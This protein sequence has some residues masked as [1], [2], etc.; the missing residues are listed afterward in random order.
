MSKFTQRS[1]ARYDASA[2]TWHYDVVALSVP[3]IFNRHRDHDPNGMLYALATHRPALQQL[4]SKWHALAQGPRT[5]AE[6]EEFTAH[7][8]VRPLVLRARV[9]DVM[10]VRF[11]NHL[12]QRHV[13]MHLV[14]PG[15]DVSSDGSAVGN[16]ASSLAAPGETV[17]YTWRC[18]HEGSF[19]F[20]DIGDPDGDETGTNAHGLFGALIVEPRH[21]W[22]TDPTQDGLVPVADGLYVDVHQRSESAL[23]DPSLRRAPF[24][25]ENT[26]RPPRHPHPR[27]SFREYVL[28][29]HDEP[30]WR[31]RLGSDELIAK[32]PCPLRH[33][34]DPVEC[35]KAAP[36]EAF[37]IATEEELGHHL[38]SLMLFNYRSEPMK[39]R[40]RLIWRWLYEKRLKETVINEEQHHSSWMFGDP[41]TPVLKSY[42]GDPARIRLLHAAV[43][44]TH[45]FHLHMYEWYRDPQNLRSP[46]IDAISI[47]PQ[48]GHTIVPL[49]GT[50]NTQAVPGDVIWHCHLYPHFHMGMWGMWRGFDTLQTGVSGSALAAGG[51]YQG[52]RIGHYPDG[53]PIER[54]A[55]LPDREPPPVPTPE[56]P[57]FP[58]FI[59]GE[60][61]QKSPKPPWPSSSPIPA[62]LDYRPAQPLE[63][64]AMNSVP[65]PGEMFTRIPHPDKKTWWADTNGD[66]VLDTLR[67]APV[68]SRVSH[69]I[70]AAHGLIEYNES[71]R[72]HD[73]D[74]HFFFLAD[75]RDPF[76]PP[77]P[78]EPLFFRARAGDVLELTFTNAIGFRKPK[79]PL[80]V[81]GP[82]GEHI[83]A[84]TEGQ[85]E[86]MHYDFNIPPCDCLLVEGETRP[87]AE[88]GLH[89][90][91]V[92]FDPISA[93]G[94]SV[95][96]NYL[97][98]PSD[99]K[100]LVYRW[101][102]DEE[103]GT[104]FFH[105][106]LFANTRQRHGLFGALIVE[107]ERSRFLDPWQEDREILVGAQAVI[108][109]A[110]GRRYRE[111]CLA[112]ADWVA[113]YQPSESSGEI[114][115]LEPPDVPSDHD[116]NGTMAVNYR[117]EPLRERGDDP[118]RWFSSA[119][120]EPETPIFHTRPGEEIRL[121]LV[122]GS[123]EEQHSL[124]VHGLRWRAFR[125][126][127]RSPVRNQQTLGIS[128]AFTFVLDDD[129]GAGDYLW[130]L[131]GADDTWLGVWG[132]IRAHGH[133]APGSGENGAG[134]PGDRVP[135]PLH[136]S[137]PAHCELPPPVRDRRRYRVTAR[138]KQI[139][140]RDGDDHRTRLVDPKGLVFVATAMAR[141]GSNEF[142]ALPETDGPLVLRCRAGEWVEIELENA[143]PAAPLSP[144][145][146]PPEVP[147]GVDFPYRVSN[148]VSLHTDLLRYDVTSS[149]GAWVGRN[150]DQTV[151]PGDRRTYLL[152][153]DVEPG[154]VLLQDMADVR[155]HRHHGLFG[156]LVVERLGF[157]PLRVPPGRP[158]APG[159]VSPQAERAWTGARATLVNAATDERIEEMV[160]LLHDG[161]RYYVDGIEN[162]GPVPNPPD[163]PGDAHGES[164]HGDGEHEGD[165]EHPGDEIKG[166]DPEDQGQKAFNYRSERIDAAF[167]DDVPLANPL[168]RFPLPAT[169]IVDV[170][171]R[172]E[173]VLRLVCAAD[174]PRNHG[175][176][177]HGHAWREWPHRGA[178]SPVMSSEGALSSSSVRSYHFCANEEPGDYLYRSSVFKWV[179]AQGAWGILRVH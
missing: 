176:T 27:A 139:V 24:P 51:V 128:E 118:H 85:L 4:A 37:P 168:F 50:G 52:R 89:V 150:P 83:P 45:V 63:L 49:Y 106:H 115:P 152:H 43:K 137:A 157:T 58:L 134:P 171:A 32:N 41:A 117:C 114:E 59:A 21:A 100:K 3:I 108:E 164:G 61:Q 55:V 20:H 165:G 34:D 96:W 11:T 46:V 5:V 101:W 149:D 98:A 33:H 78:E 92:K 93:D 148:R 116:D 71:A 127:V 107:P 146:H 175:F 144:E 14:A 77:E 30:E 111:F 129:Y 1:D 104:I 73:P 138:Q 179:V 151:A 57:G 94:A 91:I 163:I 26:G 35:P 90:H 42:V 18:H 174:K 103:F 153:A 13:G 145:R 28:L 155:N 173:V 121:R 65:K 142:E 22:W 39:N 69:H 140:Y 80:H 6:L 87:A 122:Q 36:G 120:G 16:N 178:E 126:D 135:W 84:P 12:R 143:L 112:I 75:E 113:M 86:W 105:D 166:P 15:T 2:R 167:V 67:Q 29:F 72:W 99:G 124:Q 7:P 40:E 25:G 110:N 158:S 95:G 156:A 56:R 79:G 68:P 170:P 147:V 160:L 38:P 17:V 70:A 8:L 119:E 19:V 136:P 169:P 132:F 66:G 31:E 44:E 159:E 161:V 76:N 109:L 97:S 48:T 64:A 10:V 130:R 9:G 125:R 133:G 23:R 60:L 131:A 177:L 172:A 102:C 62:D 53:T 81:H 141:P 74:G 54:L 82:S 154:A 88:C 47:T 162:E 123:H